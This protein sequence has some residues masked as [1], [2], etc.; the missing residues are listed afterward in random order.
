MNEYTEYPTLMW[1][2]TAAVT[3]P[4]ILASVIPLIAGLSTL[5]ADKVEAR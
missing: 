1:M 4:V 3:G 5:Q 2:L